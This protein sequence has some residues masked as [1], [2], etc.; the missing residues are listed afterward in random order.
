MR[1]RSGVPCRRKPCETA[2][3]SSSTSSPTKASHIPARPGALTFSRPLVGIRQLPPH[4]PEEPLLGIEALEETL[5]TLDQKSGARR[6]AP[7]ARSGAGGRRRVSGKLRGGSFPGTSRAPHVQAASSDL[8]R[9][10]GPP[11]RAGGGGGVRDRPCVALRLPGRLP[12]S[13]NPAAPGD[14]HGRPARVPPLATVPPERR[15][16]PRPAPEHRP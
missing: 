12:V 2:P 9:A 7:P 10:P 1:F 6:K 8:H 15:S 14:A 4:F 11:G 5:L 13:G 16:L 3:S